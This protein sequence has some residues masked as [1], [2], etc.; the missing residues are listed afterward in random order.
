[1]LQSED[2]LQPSSS[3][4]AAI[5]PPMPDAVVA[6]RG[7]KDEM[8]RV[9]VSDGVQ[10]VQVQDDRCIAEGQCWRAECAACPTG[11]TQREMGIAADKDRPPLI[12][13]ASSAERHVLGRRGGAPARPRLWHDA[14]SLGAGAAS[15]SER[16]SSTLHAPARLSPPCRRG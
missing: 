13:R 11:P 16:S 6:S 5:E 3:P 10:Q 9:N 4:F 1:M 7:I 12:S 15:A 8:S 2:L 14:L